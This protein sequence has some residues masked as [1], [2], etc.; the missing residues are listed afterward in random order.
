MIIQ[1]SLTKMTQILIHLLHI[2]GNII[3][4]IKRFQITQDII[5]H[6]MNAPTI[7]IVPITK[8]HSLYM[9]NEDWKNEKIEFRY[10]IDLLFTSN[11][12][13]LKISSNVNFWHLN[14]SILSLLVQHIYICFLISFNTIGC[15]VIA[16]TKFK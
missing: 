5:I 9:N 3:I 15:S 13:C 16:Q 4:W 11:K 1:L 8:L 7:N 10:Y 2:L 6:L 12:K 14:Q